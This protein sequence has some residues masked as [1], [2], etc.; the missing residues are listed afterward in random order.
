MSNEQWRSNLGYRSRGRP[1]SLVVNMTNSG[2]SLDEN[3]IGKKELETFKRS[4]CPEMEGSW[5]N[6][7]ERNTITFVLNFLF[8]NFKIS[9]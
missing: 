4:L 5:P 7:D 9:F 6:N 1:T 3:S 2:F 8:K